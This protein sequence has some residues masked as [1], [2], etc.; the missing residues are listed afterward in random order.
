M[1][2]VYQRLPK[3]EKLRI[4]SVEVFD[5]FEEFELKCS[6]YLLL[7]ATTKDLINLTDSIIP[8]KTSSMTYP[9]T[10]QVVLRP[11]ELSPDSLIMSR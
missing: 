2:D 5:E 6:H 7:C 9:L 10:A 11:V 3:T 1:N 8:N 4:N